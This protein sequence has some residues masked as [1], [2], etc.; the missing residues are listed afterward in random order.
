MIYIFTF[1]NTMRMKIETGKLELGHENKGLRKLLKSKQLRRTLAGVLLGAV[2][3]F[4][5]FYLTEGMHM[6]SLST[7]DILESLGF[8][9]LF[10][11]F[12][13]NSPCSRNSC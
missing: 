10:G 1:L 6:D 11:L 12:I 13:T 4:T 3:G 7:M 5:I 9:G 8:G 2:A